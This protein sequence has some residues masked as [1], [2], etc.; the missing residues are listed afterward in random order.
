MDLSEAVLEAEGEELSV[1]EPGLSANYT[2]VAL[3]FNT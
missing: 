2:F 1:A 3:S